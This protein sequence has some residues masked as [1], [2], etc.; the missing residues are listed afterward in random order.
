MLNWFNSKQ[1]EEFG[2]ILA[3]FLMEKLPLTEKLS[4]SKFAKKT[5]NVLFQMEIK[6]KAF[7][8][9]EKLNFYKTAKLVNAFQWKLKDIGYDKA[10][11]EKLVEWLVSHI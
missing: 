3:Q 5:E 7:K 2:S 10:L 6:I 1:A 11:T 4:E 9:K 8:Q